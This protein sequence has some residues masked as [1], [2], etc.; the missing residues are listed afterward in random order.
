MESDILQLEF[1]VFSIADVFSFTTAIVLGLLFFTV[2]SDNRRANVFLSL[3]LFSLSGEVFSVLSEQFIDGGLWE[4]EFSL[5]TMPLLLF[6]VRRTINRSNSLYTY[7]L[8]VPGL[9]FN[10]FGIRFVLFEYLFN[11]SILMIILSNLH[12][13]LHGIK[14]YFSN[15]EQVTL[16]WILVIV[17]IFLGFHVLWIIED[18]VVWQ[19]EKLEAYWAELSSLLTF[20]TIFWIGHNG[21]SQPEIF[22]RRLF[23]QAPRNNTVAT[24]E[25]EQHEGDTVLWMQLNNQVKVQHLF[26][27]PKLNLRMLAETC[28]M[29]EKE[30]SRLINQQEQCNFYTYINRYR[31]DMFKQLLNSDKAAQLSLLG[32]AEEAGFNSKSTFYSAFK[33][34]EGMTPTQYKSSLSK[35]E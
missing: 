21:F 34:I 2:K 24:K 29:S 27:N 4:I 3:F 26:T 30:V 32:L 25:Q 8:M 33:S 9:V 5:F 10:L 17:F 28:N 31:V 13:H 23:I 18:I 19:N 35:S 20:F 11:I 6:Y 22:K 1:N 12:H 16:K 15:L 7:L 14:A